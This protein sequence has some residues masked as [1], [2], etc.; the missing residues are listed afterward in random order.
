MWNMGNGTSSSAVILRGAGITLVFCLSYRFR[1]ISIS[2]DPNYNFTIDHH[3][4]TII[5]ADGQNTQPLNVDGLQIF[6]AQRY[7]FVVCVF[8]RS[9]SVRMLILT[10]FLA[11]C[12]PADRKLLDSC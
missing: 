4:M 2:C 10:L 12:Q 6:A 11:S 9:I 1:L 7:S 8:P 3:T 5:E